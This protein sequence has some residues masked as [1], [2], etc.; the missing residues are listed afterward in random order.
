VRKKRKGKNKRRKHVPNSL[1]LFLTYAYQKPLTF[2]EL[3][4]HKSKPNQTNHILKK[5]G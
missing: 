4:I 1:V 5:T 2:G 3:K